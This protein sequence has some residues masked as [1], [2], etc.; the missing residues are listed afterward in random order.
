M[1]VTA[2]TLTAVTVRAVSDLSLLTALLDLRLFLETALWADFTLQ[3][4]IMDL[5]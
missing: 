5:P 1:W 2:I 3:N 4:H